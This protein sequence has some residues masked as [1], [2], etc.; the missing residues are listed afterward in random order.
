M[1]IDPGGQYAGGQMAEF[2][3]IVYDEAECEMFNICIHYI[4][5]IIANIRATQG[6]HYADEYVDQVIDLI[7]SRGGEPGSAPDP[8]PPETDGHIRRSAPSPMTAAPL[9]RRDGR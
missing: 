7:H 3:G 5:G 8:D 6:D 4:A 1:W 2:E 9:T